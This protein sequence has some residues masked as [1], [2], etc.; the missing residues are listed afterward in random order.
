VQDS[1][2]D[3]GAQVGASAN[4]QDRLEFQNFTSWS[5]GHH[6]M[7][8]GG[9]VRY[10]RLHSISPANFGGTYTY[11]GGTGPSLDA[12]DNIIPGGTLIEIGSLERLRYENQNNV[13]SALNFE[14]R[15]AFAWSPSFASK[16]KQPPN[17]ETKAVARA[18][19]ASGAPPQKSGPAPAKTVFRGGFGIF[20]NRISEDLILQALRFNGLNQQQFVVTDPGVLDGPPSNLEISKLAAFAQPQIRRSLSP[21]LAPSYSLRS[22]FSME[23]QLP[24]HL[25]VTLT[26][27]HS[28]SLRTLRTVNVNAPL[29]GTYDPAVPSS[30]VRPLGQGSGN[31]FES[32]ANGRYVRDALGVSVNANSKKFN[33]WSSYSLGKSRSSDDG[34]SGSSFDPYDFSNE[35][36][37]SSYDVR[38]FFYASG[39]Y[40]APHGF[41]VNTFII[42][43]SGSP[44][45][46]ITGRDTNG[47][48]LFTERPAFATDLSKPGVIVT[49]LGAFDPNPSP[50]QRIIPRNFGPATGFVSLNLG[51]SKSIKFGRAIP[52]KTPPAPANGTVVTATN[53]QQPPSKQPIQRPYQLAFSLYASNALNHTNKGN[54]VGNMASP[55]FLQSPGASNSFIFGPG[56]GSRGNRQITLHVRFSF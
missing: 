3:G 53:S 46:I 14:P 19:A 29:A 22:S 32:Q 44:F 31:I 48:T 39:G 41:G 1:F 37:R 27:S 52:P 5:V 2:F 28:Q 26:Y 54:P 17:S 55:F 45:N 13:N 50:G 15:I 40:Q 23:R 56:G 24:H 8:I 7:K 16:K 9:R 36:G 18:T 12:R 25:K 6:F 35:W 11:A 4:K 30:G 43:N 42:A 20:Y 10:V 38:H 47:D 34:T 51:L 49:P 21:Q 33:F